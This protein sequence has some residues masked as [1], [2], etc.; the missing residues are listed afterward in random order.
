MTFDGVF[1]MAWYG[2]AL[3]LGLR[4]SGTGTVDEMRRRWNM[5]FAMLLVIMS[6]YLLVRAIF[7]IAE[8]GQ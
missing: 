3:W 8:G 6:V 7:A 4:I 2:L 5:T 1:L